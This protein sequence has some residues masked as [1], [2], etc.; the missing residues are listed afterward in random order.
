[1]RKPKFGHGLAGGVQ[2]GK[3][4]RL[5]DKVFRQ[6]TLRKAKGSG[7]PEHKERPERIRPEARP[8]RLNQTKS[9]AKPKPRAEGGLRQASNCQAG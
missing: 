2:G 3:R 9:P 7:A 5:T 8:L 6:Q 1:M 4:G